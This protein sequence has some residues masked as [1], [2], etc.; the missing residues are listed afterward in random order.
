MNGMCEQKAKI[1]PMFLNFG[2]IVTY[3]VAK[4]KIKKTYSKSEIVVLILNCILSLPSAHMMLCC[5][6]IKLNTTYVSSLM[7]YETADISLA[8]ICV[9][10][11]TDLAHVSNGFSCFLKKKNSAV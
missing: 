7:C 4:Y 1:T 8:G 10:V 3:P 11:C 6:I 9:C 2:D 5:V